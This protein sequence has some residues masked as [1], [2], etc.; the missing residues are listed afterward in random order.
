MEALRT[1]E[2]LDMCRLCDV[3]LQQKGKKC[4]YRCTR[5]NHCIEILSLDN[6]LFEFEEFKKFLQ[7]EGSKNVSEE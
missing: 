1:F 5:R 3:E 4:L 7:S 6:A 2:A